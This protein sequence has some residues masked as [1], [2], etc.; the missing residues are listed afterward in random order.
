MLMCN[1]SGRPGVEFCG[2]GAVAVFEEG[3]VEVLRGI[4]S[5]LMRWWL[6]LL[7]GC[8]PRRGSGRQGCPVPLVSPVASLLL[9]LPRCTGHPCQ[10]DPASPWYRF[11]ACHVGAV[12]LAR[13]VAMQAVFTLSS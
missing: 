13:S 6:A 5:I 1:V 10:P 8:G 3:P 4:H 7:T 9:L 12:A 11:A 2:E